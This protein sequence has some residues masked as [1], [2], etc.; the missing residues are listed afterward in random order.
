LIDHSNY[1]FAVM[2]VNIIAV[3]LSYNKRYVIKKRLQYFA[4]Q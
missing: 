3:F 2:V 4:Y 1:W